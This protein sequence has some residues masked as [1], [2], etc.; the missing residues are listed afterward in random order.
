MST[1]QKQAHEPPTVYKL[2]MEVKLP[3]EIR[4]FSKLCE[5]F[6]YFVDNTFGAQASAVTFVNA[7][8]TDITVFEFTVDPTK[9]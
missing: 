8:F 5:D 4:K 3:M 1:N 7:K 2:Q 6:S 9:P